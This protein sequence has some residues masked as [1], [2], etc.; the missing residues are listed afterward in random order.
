MRLE[1]A[2]ISL[3]WQVTSAVVYAVVH[4]LVSRSTECWEGV[5]CCSDCLMV[6]LSVAN[7]VTQPHLFFSAELANMQSWFPDRQMPEKIVFVRMQAYFLVL[8]VSIDNPCQCLLEPQEFLSSSSNIFLWPPVPNVGFLVQS[9]LKCLQIMSCS[10]SAF[11]LS[12]ILIG[13]SLL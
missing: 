4:M 6:P 9:L 7:P 11:L 8:S 1:N 12:R 2:K 5:M 10:I 3:A 13:F